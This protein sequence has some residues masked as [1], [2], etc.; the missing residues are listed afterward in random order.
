MTILARL[1]AALLAVLLSGAIAYADGL[2]ASTAYKSNPV[3][4]TTAAAL[5]RYMLAHPIID[6]DDGPA[7]ANITHDHRLSVRTDSAGGLCRVAGLDFTWSFVITLPKAVDYARMDSA[8]RRMWDQFTAYLKRH[9]EEHRTI[10]M[11]CGRSFVPAA[12][13]L[14]GLPGCLGMEK[15]VRAF[16]DRQYAACMDRQRAFDRGQKSTIAGLALVRAAQGAGLS[17]GKGF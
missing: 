3:E 15:K 13:K 6:P 17:A 4:G 12:T 14:T 1:S 7:F 10:F 5:W 11:D 16:V 8:T 9:E 2:S